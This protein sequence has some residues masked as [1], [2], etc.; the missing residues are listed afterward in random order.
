MTHRRKL[1]E[2]A[3]PLDAI[4]AA[5]AREKS[6]RHGHPST[7]H[8]W[9]ARRPLAAC[10]AVLFAQLVDDPSSLP[11]EF[12]TEEL[13]DAER[14]R[15]FGIIEE[16]VKWENS[17]NEEVLEAARREILKSTGG[18]PPPILDPFAGGGS[19]PLEAQRLGLEAHASDLNPVAVLIN[20]ALIEIPPKWA[21]MPPVHPDAEQRTRWKGAEGLAED[22]RLYGKW[23]RDEAEKRIGHLY[24]KA[25]LEDG[26]QADVIAWIWAR[27]VTCP[28]PACGATMPLVRSFWLSKKKGKEAWITPI[29]DTEGKAV[30]FEVMHG[31]HGPPTG[32]TIGRQGATCVV[33]S[34]AVPFNHIRSVGKNSGLGRC[35]VAVVV[36]TADGKRGY[37]SHNGMLTAHVDPI[38]LGLGT[39]AHNPRD[40]KTPNYGITDWGDLFTD[41]QLH[42]LSVHAQLVASARERVSADLHGCSGDTR[43]VSEYSVAVVTYLALGVS[44]MTDMNNSFVAWSTGRD[45]A[46][47]LFGRHA[48]P[49]VW[50][51]AE[52]NPFAGAAGDLDVTIRSM[53]RVLERLR[54]SAAGS[55]AQADARFVEVERAVVA[56]DPPYYGNI[57][58]A[59]L[60]DF[61]YAWLR[62][63]LR[64]IYPQE[65]ATVATPKREELIANTYRHG[66][67]Q[68]ASEYFAD[69]FVEVFENLRAGAR[70]DMPLTLF[71]AFKQ[72]ESAEGGLA[73]TGW[74]TILEGL[75]AAGWSVTATW[76]MRTEKAGRMIA[77]AANAL[78]SSVVLAC[79]PR[80]ETAGLTDRA[81]FVRALRD[82]LPDALR[83]LQKAHIAPVDLRQAAI[84]PGMAVF[85]RYERVVEA[86]GE[87]MRVRTALGLIN[88]ALDQ[89][90]G[91]QEA[92]F[93]PATRWAIHWF[94]QFFED[95]GPFGVA[96]SLATA[97]AIAVDGMVESGILESGGGKVRLLGRDEYP[98]DWDPTADSRVPVWEACQHLVK[99]LE[100]RGEGAAG[101]LLGQLGGLGESAQLLA[102]RLYTICEQTRPN[103][104]GPYNSLVASFDQLKHHATTRPDESVNPVQQSFDE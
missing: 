22:V 38:D 83:D 103:L 31:S 75:L 1:I 99:R 62:Q 5:S 42:M 57:G 28:N 90:M 4:N 60:S 41:R 72:S 59:D 25:T 88:Q 47:H 21:D 87:R 54:P 77:N 36:K 96:E 104:A 23:M 95:E 29:V 49:M 17:T 20:K 61:F 97:M 37:S 76:P 68:A 14:Q 3:L 93:D 34:T 65:F 43:D 55:V 10:R 53:T 16:L 64:D 24:P 50:D 80:D 89:V 35:P 86:A 58:Y 67:P 12:P 101:E 56:T 100:E 45:Q 71:Y 27:T 102:Y 11:D 2:V 91:E 98:D 63:M 51:F 39:L 48:I 92:A 52:V 78:A 8:L 44:K 7:L 79:R 9:W 26:S 46:V 66:T 84:G 73:S 70:P 18:N 94:S 19:I 82:E 69:G 85:S 30:T 15:L 13:Q 81:G 32:G 33:C 74:S 40:L 6:I